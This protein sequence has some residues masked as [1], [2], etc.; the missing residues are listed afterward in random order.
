MMAFLQRFALLIS[1]V[2]HGFDRL[3]FKGK[4][5]QLYS[6][7]GMHTLLALHQ[8]RRSEFKAYAAETTKRLLQA[9]L[10]SQAKE[11]QRFRYLNSSTVS[12]ELHFPKKPNSACED[13]VWNVD[14]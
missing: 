9:S 5:R 4:L 12:K 1:G 8:V 3:V 11:L 14:A 13:R 7:D 2:L 10:V 6:P